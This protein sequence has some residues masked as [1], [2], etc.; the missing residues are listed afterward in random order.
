MVRSRSCSPPG[1][2]FLKL[3]GRPVLKQRGNGGG[4]FLTPLTLA[5]RN[6]CV[7]LYAKLSGMVLMMLVSYKP[8]VWGRA[9]LAEYMSSMNPGRT[10]SSMS[11]IPAL[12]RKDQR[13]RA[14][15][16]YNETPIKTQKATTK[17]KA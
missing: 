2:A 5:A 15:L 3:G 8:R 4:Q 7:H 16:G 17:P 14:S 9:G 11:I 13:I 10:Q 6:T 1:T 12:R